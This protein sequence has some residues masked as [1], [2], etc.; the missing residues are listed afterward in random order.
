[1]QKV[2]KKL[3]QQAKMVLDFNWTSEYTMP[4]PRSTRTNGRGTRRSSPSATAATI[5]TAP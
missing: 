4:G 3:V 1:M 5:R 2:D